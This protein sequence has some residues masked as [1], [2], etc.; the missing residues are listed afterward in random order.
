MSKEFLE[1]L[2]P[3]LDG[4]QFDVDTVCE[5]APDRG[6]EKVLVIRGSQNNRLSLDRIDVLQKT[7]HDSLQFAEF[8][9]VVPQFCERIEFVEEEDAR[10]PRDMVEEQSQVF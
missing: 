10:T 6:I 1:H 2:P 3:R 7:H 5:P 9:L 8:L 4:G